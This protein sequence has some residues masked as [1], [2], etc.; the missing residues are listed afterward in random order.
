MNSFHEKPAFFVSCVKKTNFGA[1]KGFPRDIILSFLRMS[2][3]MSGF[4][5]TSITHIECRDV[6]ADFLFEI[7]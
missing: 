4:R 3:K 7:F 6:C 1:R 5:E 2:Q